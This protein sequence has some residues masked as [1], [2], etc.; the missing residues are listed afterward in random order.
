MEIEGIVQGEADNN[1]VQSASRINAT[2]DEDNKVW[3]QITNC[4]QLNAALYLFHRFYWNKKQ[5]YCTDLLF[6]YAFKIKVNCVFPMS[7][8]VIFN[9]AIFQKNKNKFE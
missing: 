5:I 6:A 3:T 8:Y 1:V 4:Y 7:L 2:Y 9:Y